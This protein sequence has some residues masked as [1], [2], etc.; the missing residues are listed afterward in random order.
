MVLPVIGSQ[1]VRYKARG[2]GGANANTAIEQVGGDGA[3]F[4]EC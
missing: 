1:F 3:V 2:D 4:Q